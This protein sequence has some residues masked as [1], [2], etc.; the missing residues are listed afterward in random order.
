MAESRYNIGVEE[1]QN[2][3][4]SC[5]EFDREEAPIE[6]SKATEFFFINA[7]SVLT[8]SE[9]TAESGQGDAPVEN[10]NDGQSEEPSAENGA[11]EEQNGPEANST[12]HAAGDAAGEDQSIPTKT[13]EE[14]PAPEENAE[15]NE[16]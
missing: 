1:A 8:T 5:A 6:D 10:G 12:D 3:V 4:D 11:I 9:V 13:V 15:T 14:S 2:F 16:N 7:A